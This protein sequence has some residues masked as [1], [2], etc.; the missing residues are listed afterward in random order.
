M[1]LQVIVVLPVNTGTI[2]PIKTK[3]LIYTSTTNVVSTVPIFEWFVDKQPGNLS[4]RGG[5]PRTA[6]S[7]RR[8]LL[9]ILHHQTRRSLGMRLVVCTVQLLQYLVSNLPAP[10]SGDRV[11]E[12]L[13]QFSPLP[14]PCI[15]NHLHTS[16]THTPYRGKYICCHH[17]ITSGQ[18]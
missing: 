11:V 2:T 8:V 13:L 14:L 10:H 17:T 3:H 12:A 6:T 5:Y 7:M 4:N 15:R 1:Y 16:H 9:L 18:F